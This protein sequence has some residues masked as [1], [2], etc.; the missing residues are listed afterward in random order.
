MWGHQKYSLRPP[1]SHALALISWLSAIRGTYPASIPQISALNP[2]E[3]PGWG[4]ALSALANLSICNKRKLN[5]WQGSVS[6][7]TSH[8]RVTRLQQT[9]NTTNSFNQNTFKQK[10]SALK[11]VISFWIVLAKFGSLEF[12]PPQL[13]G[14]LKGAVSSSTLDHYLGVSLTEGLSL[15][16]LYFICSTIQYFESFRKLLKIIRKNEKWHIFVQP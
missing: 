3:L 4:S 5:A 1:S 16:L 6:W 11:N 14:H 8:N 10:N 12:R 2:P 13:F 15:M 9:N 7:T